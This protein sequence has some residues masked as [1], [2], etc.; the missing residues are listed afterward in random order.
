MAGTVNSSLC[1]SL[2]GVTFVRMHFVRRQHLEASRPG[3]DAYHP[4]TPRR[5]HGGGGG[6]TRGLVSHH[7]R[8]TQNPSPKNPRQTIRQTVL[9]CGRYNKLEQKNEALIVPDLIPPCSGAR[10]F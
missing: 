1:P 3:L 7:H 8:L 5:V 6:D 10:T 2:Y 4:H 9:A